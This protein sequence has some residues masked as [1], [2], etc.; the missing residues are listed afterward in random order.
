MPIH[1]QTRLIA[2]QRE[3]FEPLI[4]VATPQIEVIDQVDPKQ[5]LTATAQRLDLP[6]PQTWQVASDAQ[7]EE[8]IPKLDF[9]AFLKLPH[10]SGG[11]GL[12]RV[13]TADRLREAYRGNRQVSAVRRSYAD[14]STGRGRGGLLRF[15]VAT[16]WSR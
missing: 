15:A 12:H 8:T 16:R 10:T 2:E 5:K 1:E 6:I 7:L 11:I 14:R 13:E 4:R 9:P 3:R